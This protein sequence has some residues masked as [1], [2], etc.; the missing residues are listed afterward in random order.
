[1]TELDALLVEYL[2]QMF[3]RGVNG[4][5]RSRLR[6]A[7]SLVMPIPYKA[8]PQGRPLAKRCATAWARWAP[9]HSRPPLLRCACL[10]FAGVPASRGRALMAI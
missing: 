2:D 9:A 3:R 8:V 4:D 7:L 1:M 5:T 6:T 10:A